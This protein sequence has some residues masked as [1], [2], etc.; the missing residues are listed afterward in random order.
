LADAELTKFF[1]IF[2]RGGEGDVGME[3]A[4][5]RVRI[6][7]EDAHYGGGL[8]AGAKILK[9]FGDV[10]TELTI[11]HDGDEGLLAGYESIEFLAPV[12]AGDFIE[13]RGRIVSV[14]KTSRKM[15]FEA[16]K[17]IQSAKV[18]RKPSAADVLEKPVTVARARGTSVVKMER[19]RKGK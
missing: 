1:I 11:R 14:G 18:P 4:L 2:D 5:I 19:Q 9:L 6:G 13:A 10:A 12:Y 7:E 8:V 3:E 15:E 16:V 17:V